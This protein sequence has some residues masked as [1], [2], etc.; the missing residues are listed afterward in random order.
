[1][2]TYVKDTVKVTDNEI[3][4]VV[5]KVL[6]NVFLLMTLALVVTGI[7]SYVVTN[8][9]E[10]LK[11]LF[12]NPGIFLGLCG[13]EILLVIILSAMINKL[14]FNVALIMFAVYSIL[15]GITIAPI[16]LLYTEDSIA[17]TFFITA[18]TFGAMALF[19]YITKLNLT[20]IGSILYMALF[21]IIIASI[22]NLFMNNSKIELITNYIGVI[23]FIGLTAYDTQ[24]I[25]VL[26]QESIKN[27]GENI[28]P[29][30]VVIGSLELYLDFINLFLKLLKL[31]G[32]KK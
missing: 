25:K 9:E 28:I 31:M 8:N 1:M 5:N 24:K 20:K 12:G 32:K 23:V 14:S 22:A 15:T 18:F 13:A 19:G 6:Y 4:S 7:T 30:I 2:S 26:V 21:G 11:G 29:K 16:F 10:L 3:S 17:S 27:K